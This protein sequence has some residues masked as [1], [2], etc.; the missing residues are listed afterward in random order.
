MKLILL[1][2][3]LLIACATAQATLTPTLN[4][5][6]NTNL[7]N[8][9]MVVAKRLAAKNLTEVVV[10]AMKLQVECQQI[11]SQDVCEGVRTILAVLDQRVASLPKSSDEGSI[12]FLKGLME[13]VD[14]ANQVVIAKIDNES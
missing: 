7:K 12:A 4:V 14:E 9:T 3:A 13:G 5:T 2:G 11:K 10:I 8:E 6:T 1:T